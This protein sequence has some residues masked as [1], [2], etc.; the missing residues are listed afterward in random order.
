MNIHDLLD[1]PLTLTV[2]ETSKVA[3][4]KLSESIDSWDKE[5][6]QRI[7][8]D[9]PYLAE[10]PFE[11]KFKNIDRKYGYAVGSI[12]F[13]KLKGIYI[14]I[15]I[16]KYEMSPLDI[17]VVNEEARPLSPETFNEVLAE[18]AQLGTLVDPLQTQQLVERQNAQ[19]NDL[20]D[21]PVAKY[22]FLQKANGDVNAMR[23]VARANIAYV[24]LFKANGTY[25]I[26]KEAMNVPEKPEM[27]YEK[28]LVTGKDITNVDTGRYKSVDDTGSFKI[29]SLDNVF[30]EGYVVRNVYDFDLEKQAYSLFITNDGIFGY[31]DKYVGIARKETEKVASYKSDNFGVGDHICFMNKTA[32]VCMSTI[33]VKVLSKSTTDGHVKI[34]GYTHNAEPITIYMTPG[35]KTITKTGNV[36]HIPSHKMEIVKLGSPRKFHWNTEVVKAA[37]ISKYASNTTRIVADGAMVTIDNDYIEKKGTL[38]LSEA[39]EALGKYYTNPIEMIKSA[40]ESGNAVFTGVKFGF[41]KK[42]EPFKLDV[43]IEELFKTAAA[44]TD[45]DSVDAVLSLGYINESNV[46]DFV[47]AIPQFEEVINKLAKMLLSIRLGLKG[48]EYSVKDA[49]K[50]LQRAVDSLKNMR[51]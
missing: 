33:P 42:A 12:L 37:G 28:E 1:Q 29:A 48:D 15:I 10:N 43:N 11:I 32:N 45:P 47:E 6:I 14:P 5:I 35:I 4:F 27:V 49:M 41:T 2:K 17:I 23:K 20:T 25:E 21:Y 30:H 9:L 18:K 8:E 16:K 46:N 26:L 7:H 50:C 19:A 39:Y 36:C 38:T 13:S 24:P 3:N 51:G 44:L 34:S 31:Q 40:T 22:G